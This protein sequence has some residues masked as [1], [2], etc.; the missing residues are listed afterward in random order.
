MT[1]I[2]YSIEINVPPEKA[3]QYTCNVDNLPN[4]LPISDVKVLQRGKEFVRL[5]HSFTAAGRTMDFICEQKVIEKN[6]K[7]Q[8][9]VVEGMKLEGTWVFEPT[10]KGTKL[11]NTLEYQAPGWIFGIVLDKFKIKKEMARICS[12]G[13]EKLKKILEAGK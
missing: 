2:E 7:M 11:T 9:K 10:E 6:R 5:R 1:R 3:S 8:Y 13:L 4:Y 12:E